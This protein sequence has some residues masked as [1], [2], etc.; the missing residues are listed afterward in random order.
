MCNYAGLLGSQ[1]PS[2]V[3]TVLFKICNGHL[4]GLYQL[5]PEVEHELIQ[6][7]LLS[8]LASLPGATS[9]FT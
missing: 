4:L 6:G 2:S 5:P 7:L 9:N 1:A 8:L 3:I